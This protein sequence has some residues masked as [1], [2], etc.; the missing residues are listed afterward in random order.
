[1]RTVRPGRNSGWNWAADEPGMI[2]PFDD[3]YQ[4]SVRRGAGEEVARVP[5]IAPVFI[6]EFV[7]VPVSLVDQ[8]VPVGPLGPGTR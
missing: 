8:S 6:V 5:A 3:L 1:M 7:P 2:L 4:T